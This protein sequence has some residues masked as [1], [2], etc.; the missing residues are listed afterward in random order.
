MSAP[1]LPSLFDADDLAERWRSADHLTVLLRSADCVFP[2]DAEWSPPSLELLQTEEMALTPSTVTA[3]EQ[4]PLAP[5]AD[6]PTIGALS[7][8]PPSVDFS[9]AIDDVPAEVPPPP[10]SPVEFVRVPPRVPSA[11]SDA[12]AMSVA[13]KLFSEH[14]DDAKV[15][16]SHPISDPLGPVLIA[17]TTNALAPVHPWTLASPRSEGGIG[18]PCRIHMEALATHIYAM[19]EGASAATVRR[20]TSMRKL[21]SLHLQ[22]MMTPRADGAY[23]SYQKIVLRSRR[24]LM[25]HRYGTRETLHMPFGN[26]MPVGQLFFTAVPYPN[27]SQAFQL[28]LHPFMRATVDF[29]ELPTGVLTA[30]FRTSNLHICAVRSLDHRKILFGVVD[31]RNRIWLPRHNPTDITEVEFQDIYCENRVRVFPEL[32]NGDIVQVPHPEFPLRDSRARKHRSHETRKEKREK[33]ADRKRRKRV[34]VFQ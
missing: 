15:A 34:G 17:T 18:T 32:R 14:E 9:L 3:D 11:F 1:L 28:V 2:T 24:V 23:A 5:D 31:C 7:D 30:V 4:T 12:A 8:V 16:L 19:P 25:P 21:F 13:M 33:D 22:R 20:I 10:P 6:T 29:D 27:Q 26:M